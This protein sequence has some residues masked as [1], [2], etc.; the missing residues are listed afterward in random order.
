MRIYLAMAHAYMRLPHLHQILRLPLVHTPP[1]DRNP[2][3]TGSQMLVRI[4]VIQTYTKSL[5]SLLCIIVNST[6]A[7]GHFPPDP[8]RL[9]PSASS[10]QGTREEGIGKGKSGRATQRTAVDLG[11]KA[12]SLGRGR[13]ALRGPRGDDND[14]NDHSDLPLT[15]KLAPG[16]TRPQRG[17]KT[18]TKPAA[19]RKRI[20]P[21]AKED[22]KRTAD[23]DG[24][25]PTKHTA[26]KSAAAAG[27]KPSANSRKRGAE[28]QREHE[29]TALR[30]GDDDVPV[31]D[32]A[33]LPPTKRV[34]VLQEKNE[35]RKR[36]D[37]TKNVDDGGAAN[38]EN[39]NGP[40]AKKRRAD[41]AVRYVVTSLPPG[42]YYEAHHMF[43]MSLLILGRPEPAGFP[44]FLHPIFFCGLFFLLCA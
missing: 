35:P 23:A 32:V 1:C 29:E 8:S 11:R 30:G 42:K 22:A 12:P 17:K 3:P 18:G 2:L 4:Y 37:R 20:A 40:P 33:A 44:P 19:R 13:A 28:E 26:N 6:S 24:E 9:A 43:H 31:P 7:T 34:R 41:P 38:N 39:E 14:D 21:K 25:E 10:L 15:Q 16:E 27:R 36:K 5:F